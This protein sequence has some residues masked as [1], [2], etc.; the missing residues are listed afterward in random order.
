MFYAIERAYG[1]HVV[2]NG[3]RA[4][5]VYQFTAKRLRDAWVA[6]GPWSSTESGYR[7]IARAT[8]PLVRSE[9]RGAYDGDAE[10]WRVVGL[11]RV[12]MSP[13]LTRY[14]DEIEDDWP[15][16]DHWR[17]VAR[18]AEAEIVSWAQAVREAREN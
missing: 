13:L 8:H 4:D 2:N 3:N 17:W 11:E 14:R 18:A 1:S 16:L 10:A 12:H 7:E 6:A 5:K 15:E 9:L